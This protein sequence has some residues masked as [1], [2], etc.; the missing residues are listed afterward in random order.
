MK[1]KVWFDKDTEEIYTDAE[2]KEQGDN[3]VTECSA[4]NSCPVELG[5]RDYVLD[6]GSDDLWRMFSPE[7]KKQICR[8]VWEDHLEY[9]DTLT[10]REIEI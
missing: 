2:M 9:D 7:A 8:Q 10:C 1:I 6:L 4:M 3:F 5:V